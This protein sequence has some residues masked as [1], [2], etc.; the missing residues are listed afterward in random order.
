MTVS[1]ASQVADAGALLLSALDAHSGASDRGE[2]FMTLVR[3]LLAQESTRGGA[4]SMEA[5]A[6]AGDAAGGPCHGTNGGRPIAGQ[7]DGLFTTGGKAEIGLSG[8]REA[9]ERLAYLAG[10]GSIDL[11]ELSQLSDEELAALMA[12]LLAGAGGLFAP[13]SDLSLSVSEDAL[14]EAA[15]S[16]SDT[17]AAEGLRAVLSALTRPSAE[18]QGSEGPDAYPASSA[19]AAQGEATDRGR[20]GT[21]GGQQQETVSARVA[22]LLRELVAAQGD[23]GQEPSALGERLIRELGGLEALSPAQER[24][25]A[26]ALARRLLANAQAAAQ[27]LTSKEGGSTRLADAAAVLTEEVLPA[28]EAETL[29]RWL[30]AA[31][32]ETGTASALR[33]EAFLRELPR[34]V[35][36][37]LSKAVLR[38]DGPPADLLA[39]LGLR[40]FGRMNAVHHPDGTQP[41][42]ETG[43]TA[44]SETAQQAAPGAEMAPNGPQAATDDGSANAGASEA[45]DARVPPDQAA[46]LDAELGPAAPAVQ[47]VP[48][49]ATLAVQGSAAELSVEA[50]AAASADQASNA[51][52]AQLPEPP[53][54]G[55]AERA[56]N[57]ERVRQAL[58]ICVRRGLRA[59]SLQ[60]EPP[61]LG[62]LR[63]QVTV[64][65]GVVHAIVRTETAEAQG[66][67]LAGLDQ[68][69][70]ALGVQELELGGF[71][72]DYQSDDPH[73]SGEEG[74][75]FSGRRHAQVAPEADLPEEEPVDDLL[76]P[77]AG[78]VNMVA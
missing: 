58:R 17:T 51:Q 71:E 52:E 12:W 18:G 24:D 13:W 63:M 65:Q 15:A 56:Q 41:Q 39:E 76:L 49:Q 34:P 37:A 29:A 72:V 46:L 67:L 9:M 3:R 23:S 28:V 57:L 55:P 70:E 31:A 10:D 11:D 54:F 38:V 40:A 61:Q 53:G 22:D 50:G 48:S 33:E 20:Q 26:A 30:A 60:L 27:A 1:A 43:Q 32:R 8:L 44:L 42:A 74:Q 19:D 5:P 4:G 6:Q 36:L 62:R 73:A 77:D 47:T 45:I 21:R 16:G 66:L 14:N 64:E 25:L 75:Q 78:R 59:A 7:A 35:L 68:L 69:R 2:G